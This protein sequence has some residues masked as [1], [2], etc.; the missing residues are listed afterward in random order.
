MILGII[1]TSGDTLKIGDP[2]GGGFFAGRMQYADGIY[3]LIMGPRNQDISLLYK[4]TDTPDV[5][6]NSRFDGLA[7]TLAINDANHPLAQHFTGLNISG[8]TG[9]YIPSIDEFELAY[10]NFKPSTNPNSTSA[11]STLGAPGVNVNSIPVGVAHTPT[12]PAQT[13]LPAFQ[14]GMANALRISE[15]YTSMDIPEVSTEVYTYNTGSGFVG[16]QPKTLGLLARPFRRIK[17]S[18]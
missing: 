4:T 14:D 5:G 2:Y 7:N 17:I 8:F 13:T 3:R 12:V 9:W 18:N 6:A 11:Y 1:A 15:Y 10:R 16:S